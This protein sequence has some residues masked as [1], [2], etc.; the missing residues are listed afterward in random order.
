ME[1]GDPMS[2]RSKRAN[3][4]HTVSL[5]LVLVACAYQIVNLMNSYSELWLKRAWRTRALSAD[6]RNALFLLGSRGAAYMAFL[7]STVPLD[8]SIV[9]PEGVGEFSEQNILQFFL[10]PRT[11]PGCMC[12]ADVDALPSTACVECLRSEDN[13][14]P[15]IG[16]FPSA[17]IL[18]GVKRLVP[19]E[20]NGGWFH[21]VYV[22]R[23][24]D[25]DRG[26]TESANRT[27][28]WWFAAAV[29]LSLLLAVWALGCNLAALFVNPMGWKEAASL[30][31]PL[32]LGVLTLSV[33]LMS[34]AG[35]RL[36]GWTFVFA[37][38]MLMAACYLVRRLAIRETERVPLREIVTD[39]VS[40]KARISPTVVFLILVLGFLGV[41]A[42]VISVSRGYSI[43][44]AIANWAL[45][46]YAIAM[47]GTIWAGA[48]WGGHGLA[49]PQNLH[50]A[51]AMFR[52]FDGDALP[53]SKLLDPSFAAA[54][55]FGF[56]RLWRLK[57]ASIRHSL[58]GGILLLSTPVF[59]IHTTI[60]Y[61]NLSFTAYLVI[62]TIWLLEGLDTDQPRLLALGAL[63]LGLA[64]WTRPEGI[65]FALAIGLPTILV[66]CLIRRR[67]A[68]MTVALLPYF[69]VSGIWLTFGGRYVRAD[70][71]GQIA[72]RFLA[73]MAD[74]AI[75]AA[76]LLS[77]VR[78]ALGRLASPGIW[79]VVLP[80]SVL[81]LGV[82]LN[83]W[84]SARTFLN[85]PALLGVLACLAFEVAILLT[86]SYS[87]SNFMEDGFDRAFLPAG[88][89]I[90]AVLWA[91]GAGK[92]SEIRLAEPLQA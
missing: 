92:E 32:G 34:W 12:P 15:S 8:A 63:L 65:V 22:P 68:A 69:A 29:D 42:L 76:Y 56:Y 71:V 24:G 74:G 79:G 23:P 14:V 17:S 73:G 52:L 62:G 39:L 4:F 10:M 11:V 35:L 91:E 61:A 44:D 67:T 59:F 50:L 80:V 64:G 33:F 86:S 43:F 70:E 53:G 7:G 9:V 66:A 38:V 5:L 25:S 81:M 55:I 60:G 82:A 28:P 1:V 2:Q 3:F 58:L 54:M 48:R 19:F 83:K 49:Y 45:K 51:I 75:D 37:W 26:A 72:Y 30:G 21:G 6:A 46:G 57:G 13:F 89:L 84:R 78:L 47:E 87:W 18:E 36:T 27:S 85:L 41:Q 90:F 40:T 20:L 88:A 77:I 16:N 31:V